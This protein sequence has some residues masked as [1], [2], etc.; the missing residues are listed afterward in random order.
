LRENSPSRLP[1]SLSRQRGRGRADTGIS[2]LRRPAAAPS[3]FI[4]SIRVRKDFGSKE[5]VGTLTSHGKTDRAYATLKTDYLLD[6]LVIQ[7]NIGGGSVHRSDSCP[8][9]RQ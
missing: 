6:S 9:Y 5:I 2:V 1:P 3:R 4:F 7:N 8:Q